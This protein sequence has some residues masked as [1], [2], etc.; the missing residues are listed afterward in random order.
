MKNYILIFMMAFLAMASCKKTET[1]TPE[2]EGGTIITSDSSEFN[3]RLI[4][5]TLDYFGGTKL[6]N[7]DVYLFTSYDDIYRQLYLYTKK[8][9]S[10]AVVDFGYVLQGNYYVVSQTTTKRDTS[11]VQVLGG[12]GINRNVY[13]R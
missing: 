9:N 6:S 1:V 12:R 10:N 4:I 3:G 2:E 11:L 7:V 13:L 8:S 5:N